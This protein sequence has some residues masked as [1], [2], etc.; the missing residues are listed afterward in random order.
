MVTISGGEVLC[1]VG[2]TIIGGKG[3]SCMSKTR[4]VAPS[5]AGE[6]PV[7][8]QTDEEVAVSDQQPDLSRSEVFEILSNQRR[9]YA[10]HHLKQ[11][12]DRADLGD[13]AEH[14]AAW[15]NDVEVPAISSAE[16]KR[17]YTSLQQFHL[18]KL[19]DKGVL[20]FDDREG[21]VELTSMAEDMDIYLEVVQGREIPWSQ[22]YLALAGVNLAILAGASVGVPPLET[23]GMGAWATFVAVTFL[24]SAVFHTYVSRT[25]MRLGDTETPPELD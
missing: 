5:S 21:V 4:G 1:G 17:V 11:N 15:E 16:R 25:E 10:L 8:S 23:I 22:Y 13:I 18:P 7:G 2:E 12:G 6:T 14:V 9:R 20:E 24:A 19:D 3:G